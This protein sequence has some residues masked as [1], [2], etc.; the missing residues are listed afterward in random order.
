[1]K[2]SNVAAGL[3]SALLAM[4]ASH[5]MAADATA[6]EGLTL[7]EVTVTA[8]RVEQDLQKTPQFISVK[9][10]AEL[11]AEG[12][13][14]V[15]DILGGVVGL[16]QQ[17]DNAGADNMIFM[18]GISSGAA[19]V[20]IVV[21][22]V[23]Q[24]IGTQSSAAVYRFTSLDVGQVAI[25]RGVQNGAG[26]SAL[27]GTV[28]LVTNK[29]VFENQVSGSFTTGSFKTQNAEGVINM[30]L[31]SNQAVRLAFST[32]RRDSYASS[33]LGEVDNRAMRL[34]YRWKPSD[35]LDI[36]ASYQETR[37]AG[38][39][40]NA[41]STLFTGRWMQVPGGGVFNWTN[42]YSG[43][44]STWGQ[45]VPGKQIYY[46]GNVT[47]GYSAAGN[48]SLNNI[49]GVTNGVGINTTN[50]SLVSSTNNTVNNQYYYPAPSCVANT[51]FATAGP[52]AGTVYTTAAALQTAL[53]NMG[54]AWQLW[55]CPYN[56]MAIRDGVDWNQR[57]NPWD[58][59]FRPG[60]FANAPSYRA[61]NRQASV[62]ID[63]ATE[64]GNLQMQ[65]SVLYASNYIVEAERGTTWME[66]QTLPTYSYRFD[67]SFTSKMIGDFQYI[68]GLNFNQTA[69]PADGQPSGPG[70]FAYNAPTTA[71]TVLPG[72]GAAPGY[73]LP[74]AGT[75]L[76]AAPN[77]GVVSTMNANC[78]FVLPSVNAAGVVQ[79]A[80]KGVVNNS[81]CKNGSYSALGKQRTYAFSTNFRYTLWDK[82]HLE[83][84]G[85]YENTLREQRNAA[86]AF[87]MDSDGSAFV[88]V[89][90]QSTLAFPTGTNPANPNSSYAM[91]YRMNL[92][93][94]DLNAI[95]NAYPAY[96]ASLGANSF[97]LN[98]Q[99]DITPSIITYARLA[100]GTAAAMGTDA[101]FRPVN[102]YNIAL[103]DAK[104]PVF[105]GGNSTGNATA[106]ANLRSGTPYELTVNG[107]YPGTRL[108]K[109]ETTRQLTYGF[110]T[111]WFDNRLQVNAEGFYNKFSNRA[112]TS[113]VGAFPTDVNSN[114]NVK[115]GSAT[116]C[117]TGS[118]A[119]TAQVPFSI[120]LDPASTLTN[121]SGSC[122]NVYGTSVANGPN[123]QNSPYTGRM[124]TKGVDFDITWAPT[125]NDRLDIQS[126][127]LSTQFVGSENL[128]VLTVDSLK[129]FVLSGS[130]DTV[131][132]Y[133]ASLFNGFLDGVKGQQLANAPK[134][135]VNTTYQHRF[136]L[137]N[138]WTITPRLQMN[139][140]AAKYL[141]SG[142]GGDPATDAN[143]ILD[144]NWAIENHR[145]LPTVVPTNR[146]WN[147]FVSFQPSGAKWFV[148]AYVNNIRNTAVLNSTFSV[149]AYQFGS[150]LTGDLQRIATG[151]NATL[152]APRVIGVTISAQL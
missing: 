38:T 66:G 85:R 75:A 4:A 40:N 26:V 86:P 53:S 131:L 125:A 6:D 14:R 140:T 120:V 46:T 97:T 36:N 102:Q 74:P 117:N 60:N 30:A 48:G 144:N 73:G 22:G 59:G 106:A 19:G 17:T 105:N 138:G 88:Y 13:V 12:K 124:V 103:P 100:T 139:Y 21:D 32:E 31:T 141:T 28:G 96:A 94:N 81:Y 56:M 7:E 112:L 39:S 62:T 54:P 16:T 149:Q 119:P 123:L 118:T 67:S 147:A 34:R 133:Y 137:E 129:P 5:S 92:S 25:T 3:S 41:S 114:T 27:S 64:Y 42:P 95:I 132:A 91:P 77:G 10:G 43:V 29:P 93:N 50:T 110:K 15:E 111:R 113:I 20:S 83:A 98:V 84:T 57:S 1:M 23:A 24:Q 143:T 44:T 47:A 51:A 68:L 63:W 136:K 79:P 104:V 127:L 2:K 150:R 121:L 35:N 18:R 99:Y 65:P 152:G 108:A 134:L 69:P 80:A 151:G 9:S 8:E 135:T 78:Y 142:G 45:Q 58:D 11:K 49:V 72:A 126:E 89:I 55:G 70:A 87:N 61:V 146:I 101:A 122:F 37:I 148:N 130:N 71:W 90:P 116:Q 145:Y 33:G 76:L 82:L 128:P 115:T 107:V 109:G 52:A